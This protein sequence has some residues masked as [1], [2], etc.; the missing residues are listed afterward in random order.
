MNTVNIESPVQQYPL[1]EKEAYMFRRILLTISALLLVTSANVALAIP[2]ERVAETKVN[3]SRS[4]Q[5]VF[6]TTK[7][8]LVVVPSQEVAK[9][10]RTLPPQT[11]VGLSSLAYLPSEEFVGED[12]C[13]ICSCNMWIHSICWYIVLP[14]MDCWTHFGRWCTFFGG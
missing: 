1:V 4:N 9:Y 3:R 5:F 12:T 11:R 14:S 10:R 13:S 8:R 2:A 7:G 6:K